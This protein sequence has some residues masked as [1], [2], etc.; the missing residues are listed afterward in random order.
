MLNF[1]NKINIKKRPNVRRGVTRQT[2]PLDMGHQLPHKSTKS[3]DGTMV[4][5]KLNEE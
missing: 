4:Q 1:R 3:Y 2:T 5:K